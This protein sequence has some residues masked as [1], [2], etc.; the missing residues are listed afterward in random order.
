[1]TGPRRLV[2]P[3]YESK[4]LTPFNTVRLFGHSKA[5]VSA[6]LARVIPAHCRVFVHSP[7][8][9]SSSMLSGAL[10]SFSSKVK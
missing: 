5:A 8:C 6:V 9:F 4:L 2:F 10:E 7:C 1:M 3:S